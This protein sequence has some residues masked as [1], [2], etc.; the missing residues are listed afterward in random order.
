MFYG[1][2]REE[3]LDNSPRDLWC[4]ED[5][6]ILKQKYDD[7]MAYFQGYYN[8]AAFGTVLSNAFREKGKK[9]EPYLKQ[10][11]L[12]E[13]EERNRPLSEEEKQKQVDAHFHK[14]EIMAFNE[15]LKKMR[16][17]GIYE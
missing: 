2:S 9:P 12:Q 15:K 5:A 1:A 14:L 11:I 10:P 17:T 4:Y 6:F 3:V 7:Q 13:I 8:Y 16:E